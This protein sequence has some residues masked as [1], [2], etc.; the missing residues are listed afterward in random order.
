MSTHKNRCKY[1]N[2]YVVGLELFWEYVIFLFWKFK[3]VINQL[4]KK[5][6]RPPQ[7]KNPEYHP[8]N[9]PAPCDQRDPAMADSRTDGEQS[10]N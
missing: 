6:Q 2:D 3:K 10:W 9:P 7:S 4:P 8:V 1:K 5:E